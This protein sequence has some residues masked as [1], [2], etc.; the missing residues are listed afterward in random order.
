MVNLQ[1]NLSCAYS[2]FNCALSLS[3]RSLEQNISGMTDHYPSAQGPPGIP[4]VSPGQCWWRRNR[5]G[6]I[7]YNGHDNTPMLH[8]EAITIDF[9]RSQC[10]G[11]VKR[12]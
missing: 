3:Y 9:R 6:R 5:D 4:K 10:I 12:L 7:R 1:N 2:P 8:I 11:A